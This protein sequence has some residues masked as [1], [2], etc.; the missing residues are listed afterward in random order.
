MKLGG[1]A[2]SAGSLHHLLGADQLLQLDRS[3]V[4]AELQGSAQSRDPVIDVVVVLWTV[5]QFTRAVRQ[6]KGSVEKGVRRRITLLKGREIH[7]GFERRSTLEARLHRPVELRAFEVETADHRPDGAGLVV[8]GDE[9]TLDLGFLEQRHGDHRLSLLG[10]L[11]GQ[12]DKYQIT[13]IE[14]PLHGHGAGPLDGL[15]IEPC[16]MVAEPEHRLPPTDFNHH[17][18]DHG[19][20]CELELPP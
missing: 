2:E 18:V 17:R 16:A 1:D 14:Q 6:Q 3:R 19:V 13:D 4:V 11:L 12:T 9:G 15:H 10:E 7:K 20:R 8:H 5:G